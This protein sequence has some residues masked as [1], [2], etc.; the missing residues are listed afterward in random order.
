LGTPERFQTEAAIQSLH[1][2][3][4]MTGERLT[5]PLV[6][7]YDFL[8]SFAPTTGVLVACAVAIAE[9]GDPAA[10]LRQLDAIGGAEGYQPWP[11]AGARILWLDGKS[12]AARDAA[13]MTAGLSGDPSIRC[14]LLDRGYG[15]GS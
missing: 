1:A 13:A 11:A 3:Q 2:Q 14:F 4:R 10:A 12:A 15:D 7:L 6:Q 9:D 8:A 5:G